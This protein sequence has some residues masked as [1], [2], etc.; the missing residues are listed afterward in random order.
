MPIRCHR[1]QNKKKRKNKNK[2]KQRLYQ[3][4][5]YQATVTLSN[6]CA[7][8][9]D[10]T[11]LQ[12]FP[13]RTNQRFQSVHPALLAGT[14]KKNARTNAGSCVVFCACDDSAKNE[15]GGRPEGRCCCRGCS[16]IVSVGWCSVFF[17]KEKQSAGIRSP[18]RTCFGKRNK[19]SFLSRPVMQLCGIRRD[20]ERESAPKS[21]VILTCGSSGLKQLRVSHDR[22]TASAQQ[23]CLQQRAAT[24][25]AFRRTV[26]TASA[27]ESQQR[28]TRHPLQAW[29]CLPFCMQFSFFFSF[30]LP[31]LWCLQTN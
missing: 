14:E 7:K 30:S 31:L 17:K 9:K 2:D 29:L 16:N 25:D 10:G 8:K 5:L 28:K 13:A 20:R 6:R 15:A 23:L 1:V 22:H 19:L 4:R 26:C 21:G 12:I 3:Q 27:S 18:T 24:T 11:R